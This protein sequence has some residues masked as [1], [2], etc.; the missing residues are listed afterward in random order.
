[1]GNVSAASHWERRGGAGVGH[2]VEGREV[3][4][5]GGHAGH[6]QADADHQRDQ[7]AGLRY[8]VGEEEHREHEHEPEPEPVPE[9]EPAPDPWVPPGRAKKN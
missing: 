7:P 3:A 4:P 5:G 1:M 8:D 9:P 6:E 2:R